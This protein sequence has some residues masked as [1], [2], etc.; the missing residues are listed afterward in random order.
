[1]FGANSSGHPST[2]CRGKRTAGTCP[3]KG[4]ERGGRERGGR[5]R[6]DGEGRKEERLVLIAG[7]IN[8]EA[9]DRLTVYGIGEEGGIDDLH[10]PLQSLVVLLPYSPLAHEV[11][12]L[13]T[14]EPRVGNPSDTNHVLHQFTFC[15]CVVGEC[16]GLH[17]C[18]CVWGGGGGGIL[19]HQL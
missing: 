17:V 18:V 15:V 11:G 19:S 9:T 1:M 16:D 4:R 3:S 12:G 13:S 2:V 6:G 5:E 10:A 7:F 8:A 14:E